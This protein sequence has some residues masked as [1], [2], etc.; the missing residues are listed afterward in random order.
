[1]LKKLITRFSIF[2]LFLSV[3]GFVA[4]LTLNFTITASHVKSWV[5]ESN[6]KDVLPEYII[7]QFQP[8]DE[9]QA[10]ISL[11]DP[12]IKKAALDALTPTIIQESLD[13]MVD[14]TFQWL[15]GTTEK[16]N[17]AIN[18]K[19]VK[20]NFA[21]NV[22]LY[23]VSRYNSLPVCPARTLPKTNDPLTIDCKPPISIN[24]E[25]EAKKYKIDLLS[26]EDL[27]P[28]DVIS[29]ES[30]LNT[31]TSQSNAPLN[32]SNL[33]GIYQNSRRLP[34][35]FMLFIVIC[36]FVIIYWNTSRLKG[37]RKVGIIVTIASLFSTVGT[38]AGGKGINS[39]QNSLLQAGTVQDN[40]ESLRKVGVAI[41]ASLRSEYMHNSLTIA[42]S[43]LVLGLSI[44]IAVALLSRRSK[45]T[46]HSRP[47]S[48]VPINAPK[49]EA[50]ISSQST[51]NS[52]NDL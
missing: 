44:I 52:K 51:E 35:L 8:D 39:I 4:S 19:Q 18:T 37:L 28:Q 27:L 29:S 41:I 15:D 40:Q 17:I 24:I 5:R 34:L 25:Q 43:F 13:K 7:N 33:P 9:L 30:V 26:N 20:Q 49:Q 46:V 45:N 22:E 2:L 48:K 10:G 32:T 6:V 12:N 3:I 50:T 16:P 38:L 11:R 31:S 14:G 1:M 47:N 42:G 21:D 23:I 36:S